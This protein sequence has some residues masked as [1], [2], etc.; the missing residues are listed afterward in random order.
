MLNFNLKPKAG[1]VISDKLNE[2]ID[3]ALVKERANEPIRDYLGASQLGLDCSRALQYSFLKAPKDAGREFSGQTLRI[4]AAGHVFETLA[5]DWLKLSGFDL[6][7]RDKDGRQFGFKV[8]GGKIAGHV[9]GIIY[10][11]PEE[12]NLSYPMLWEMKSMNDKSWKDTV[13][14]GLTL[15]KPVY[16]SQ[17]ALYQ[18]YMEET[19][20][21]ISKNLCLFTAINKN[22]AELYH[23]LIPYDGELAQRMSDRAVN[24][25]KATNTGEILPRPYSVR[26]F[27]ECK[28][29]AWQNRCWSSES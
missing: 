23:E 25:I 10:G 15:S 29:C 13:K 14:Q 21:G 9:D 26:N 22:T 7:N 28:M 4:F 24:I 12:L 6:H 18:A 3:A 5:I 1:N 16:A 8:A 19:V 27:M 20:E 11:A 17:I 2:L